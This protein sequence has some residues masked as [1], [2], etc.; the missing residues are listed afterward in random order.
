MKTSRLA[1]ALAI[2]AAAIGG[3]LLA[4]NHQPNT[5]KE[6]V[7][8]PENSGHGKILY[9]RNPMGLP[10]TSPGPKK[11][12]MGMDYVPVYENEVHGDAGG[13]SI[14]PERVQKLGVHT[15]LAERRK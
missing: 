7:Q 12:S 15:A 4:Q 3:Y 13:V 8:A 9:Y 11:D 1:I 6:Q 5:P 14:S 10:D 2:I